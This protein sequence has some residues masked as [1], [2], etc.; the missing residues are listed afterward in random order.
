[1]HNWSAIFFTLLIALI[2]MIMP[3]PD[4]ALWYRPAWVLLILIYWTIATPALVNVGMAWFF[5]LVVDLLTGSLLGEHALAYT[6]VIYLVARIYLR[7]RMAPI[8]QQ[9]VSVLFFVL[10]YQFVV[11]C[12]QGFTGELPTSSLYWMSSV[13]SMLVWPWLFV[14]LHMLRRRYKIA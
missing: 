10:I 9:A 6:I 12:I 3:I 14:F 8:L 4:W 1:M 11:Y 13:T 2:L 7:L 5:G